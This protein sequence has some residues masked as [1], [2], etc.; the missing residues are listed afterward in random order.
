MQEVAPAG[1]CVRISMVCVCI[2][3]CACISLRLALLLP[4]LRPSLRLIPLPAGAL[5]QSSTLSLSASKWGP[6]TVHPKPKSPFLLVTL[7]SI[8]RAAGRAGMGPTHAHTATA[9]ATT[10]TWANAHPQNSHMHMRKQAH[11]STNIQALAR[12]QMHAMTHALTRSH[13]P[14]HPYILLSGRT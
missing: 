12:P 13:P 4:S 8:A 10:H 3:V 2:S 9:H 11:A 1:V 5:T 14:T 7:M 6:L